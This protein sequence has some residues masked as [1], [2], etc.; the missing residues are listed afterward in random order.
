MSSGN[1]PESAGVG[2][3]GKEGKARAKKKKRVPDLWTMLYVHV[4]KPMQNPAGV[5]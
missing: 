5:Q 2:C 3:A 4:A 1:A